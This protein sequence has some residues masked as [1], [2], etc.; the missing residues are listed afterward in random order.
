M[1]DSP[2]DKRPTVYL[3]YAPSDAV[4]ADTL[5]TTLAAQRDFRVA[6]PN[7]SALERQQIIRACQRFVLLVTPS[8]TA[9]DLADLTIAL[10]EQRPFV[11]LHSGLSTSPTELDFLPKAVRSPQTNWIEF[12]FGGAAQ[13]SKST[14]ATFLDASQDPYPDVFISYARRNGDFARKLRDALQYEG[15]SVWLDI[16]E[17]DMGTQ[18]LNEILEGISNTQNFV[19]LK[20]PHSTISKVCNQELKQALDKHVMVLPVVLHETD[21]ITRHLAQAAIS[22]P[23]KD[24]PPDIEELWKNNETA[25]KAFQT[26]DVEYKPDT[27]ADEMKSYL[28]RPHKFWEE[29]AYYLRDGETLSL[30]APAD[31]IQFKISNFDE[32]LKALSKGIAI[33]RKFKDKRRKLQQRVDEW[34][35]QGRTKSLLLNRKETQEVKRWLSDW[36]KV[37]QE[38]GETIEPILS[39]A[40]QE[41]ITASEKALQEAR[42]KLFIGSLITAGIIIVILAGL[43]IYAFV[44]RAT[45]IMQ[46]DRA[47][48]QEQIARNEADERNNQLQTVVIRDSMVGV[49]AGSSPR[50]PVLVGGD[51]WVTDYESTLIY[52]LAADTGA[53]IETLEVGEEALPPVWDGQYL[54]V[55]SARNESIMRINP[56]DTSTALMLELDG[57]P[58]EIIP[59]DE[60]LWVRTEDYV[61]RLNRANPERDTAPLDLVGDPER[62]VI[63]GVAVWIID[64]DGLVYRFDPTTGAELST[65][66]NR[67]RLDGDP[68]GPVFACDNLWLGDADHTALRQYNPTSGDLLHE[69]EIGDQLT[70]PVIDKTLADSCDGWLWLRLPY[71]KALLQINPQTGTIETQWQLEASPLKIFPMNQ[72]VWVFTDADKL[73]LIDP[74]S[75]QITTTTLRGIRDFAAPT[76]DGT[77]LW[78][79]DRAG[80]NVAIVDATSGRFVREIPICLQPYQPLFDGVNMWVACANESDESQPTLYRV[81]AVLSYTGVESTTDRDASGNI[82]AS[83]SALGSAQPNAR[84]FAPLLYQNRLWV[85]QE[86]SGQVIVFDL[87]TERVVAAH[88]LDSSPVPPLY[89]PPYLWTSDSRDVDHP[90]LVRFDMTDPSA[91]PLRI[92]MPGEPSEIV[93]VDNQLWVTLFTDSLSGTAIALVMV[94]AD[95]GEILDQVDEYLAIYGITPQADGSVWIA[96]MLDLNGELAAFDPQSHEILQRIPL[97]YSPWPPLIVGEDLW[98]SGAYKGGG[99]EAF[100]TIFKGE[101]TNPNEGEV[102]YY[103]HASTT[104]AQTFHFEATPSALVNAGKYIWLTLSNSPFSINAEFNLGQ[105]TLVAIDPITLEVIY[106]DFGQPCQNMRSPFYDQAA[107]RLWVVCRGTQEDPGEVLVVNPDTLEVVQQ[108]HE[109]GLGAWAAQRIGEYIWI[110]YKESGTALVFRPSDG[111]LLRRFGLG[112]GPSPTILDN[113]TGDLWIVN[114]GNSTIQRVEFPIKLVVHQ[115]RN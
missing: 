100:S 28:S 80:R 50:P 18:W 21:D 64:D 56:Q 3:S 19:Y 63:A 104:P 57:A 6:K 82:S 94:D 29:S 72:R 101:T 97:E 96:G 65:L 103:S 61:Y 86:I 113:I 44:Q 14:V 59:L 31:A 74:A 66:D 36:Q 95:S 54:W 78:L 32:L 99:I 9:A 33:D 90:L 98:I 2:T 42:Q 16:N 115:K 48:E 79:A 39:S 70:T 84:A 85:V 30:T 13:P 22:D 68:V 89:D 23:D 102:Y 93:K 62:L 87:T 4:L 83:L 24:I 15:F 69:L 51:L 55:G 20:S 53:L 106:P 67:L 11:G 92:E 41:Y 7:A 73:L 46:R 45:A 110:V 43:S 114:S 38:R 111:V 25:L 77:N 107:N 26:I 88:T 8:L 37:K 47:N 5:R 91:L 34:L 109:L 58:Q 12:E 49:N 112:S 35:N 60:W 108:Y 40:Q 81:P 75:N 71:Q 105:H 17:I 27:T 10:Q 52:R 1:T 76:Y